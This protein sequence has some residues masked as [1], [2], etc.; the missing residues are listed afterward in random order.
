MLHHS[1]DFCT[2]RSRSGSTENVIVSF[3]GFC[4]AHGGSGC[5]EMLLRHSVPFCVTLAALV[6]LIVE[7]LWRLSLTSCVAPPPPPQI[8]SSLSG[9]SRRSHFTHFYVTWQINPSILAIEFSQF[10]PVGWFCWC[11]SYYAEYSRLL[12]KER[13]KQ[14]NRQILNRNIVT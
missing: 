5:V 1:M 13:K 3:P 10:K 8:F 7:A 12:K 2:T 9:R 4:L 14:A 11:S 6:S